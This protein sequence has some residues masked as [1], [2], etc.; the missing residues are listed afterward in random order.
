[1]ARWADDPTPSTPKLLTCN[2]TEHDNDDEH[3]NDYFAQT[4]A[5]SL[6][7]VGPPFNLFSCAL[8]V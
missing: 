2:Q 4:S 3:E 1:M 7:F 5:T 8:N 6:R